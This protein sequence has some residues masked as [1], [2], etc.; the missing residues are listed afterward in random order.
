M[1][2][3]AVLM[4]LSI[5]SVGLTV[6]VQ[7][8]W[9]R[10]QWE[11]ALAALVAE[12][13]VANHPLTDEERAQFE[14]DGMLVL[15]GALS[16]GE[17]AELEAALEYWSAATTGGRGVAP[18]TTWHGMTFSSR[19]D[20]P[21]RYPGLVGVLA[22]HRLLGKVVGILGWNIACY[23]A[24]AA[25]TQAA[26]GAVQSGPPPQPR[27]DHWHQDSGRVNA[28]VEGNPRPR[29]SVKASIFLTDTTDSAAPQ[30]WAVKG[31]HLNNSLPRAAPGAATPAGAAP[32]P[33]RRG[34]VVIIDRRLWHAGPLGEQA[35][36]V[37]RKVLFF[38]YGQRWLRPKDPMETAPLLQHVTCP[39]LRQ[40]LGHT[41]TSNGL[42]SPMA[43]DAP[44]LPWL[45]ARG[46][47]DEPPPVPWEDCSQS[48]KWIGGCT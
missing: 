26:T 35:Y 38:G 1:P 22:H 19:H 36:P 31:S 23:H 45:D 27:G 46:M 14:A 37:T 25:Y 41:H 9:Q 28:D 40:L 44:L 33:G 8:H 32:V 6:V 47:L 42:Y 34:D 16:E 39:V 11:G 10:W 20:A 4:L 48:S 17:V 3:A 12:V 21:L 24:H 2:T 43:A 30:F 5:L 7:Q 18:G 13:A 15:H 29:L